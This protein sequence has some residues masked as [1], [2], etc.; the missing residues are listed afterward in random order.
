VQRLKLNGTGMLKRSSASAACIAE[1][2]RQPYGSMA[3]GTME[4]RHVFDKEE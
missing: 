1:D 4:W 2:Y 3:Y